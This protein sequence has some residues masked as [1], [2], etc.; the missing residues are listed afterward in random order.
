MYTYPNTKP[1]PVE[2]FH[3]LIANTIRELQDKVKAPDALAA[4]SCLTAM[5]V[6]CQGLIDVKSP[7]GQV[8]PVSLDLLCLAESGERKSTLDNLASVALHAADDMRAGRYQI[9]LEEYF[10][11]KRVWSAITEALERE[12]KKAAVAGEPIDDIK[13][14]LVEHLRK[15]PVK[16]RLRRMMR[17]RMADRA[18]MEALQG[19][20]ESIGLTTDEG[21]ITLNGKAMGSL[22]LKNSTW[23]GA[24]QLSWDGAEGSHIVVKN[25]RV[26]LSVMVQPAV[27]AEYLSRHGDKARGSGFWARHLVA[28]PASTQGFRFIRYIEDTWHH[29]PKFHERVTELLREYDDM[30]SKGLVQRKIIEFSE[31][32]IARWIDMVNQTE[33]ML[34]PYGYLNDIKDFASKAMEIAVRVAALLHHFTKQE[35]KITVDTLNR[36]ID[37]VEW[38]LHEFK[39]LFSPQ[40]QAPSDQIDAAALERYLLTHY[41]SKGVSAAPRNSVLRNGPVRPVAAFRAALDHLER[42]NKIWIGVGVGA[43]HRTRYINPGPNF[44]PV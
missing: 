34:Q 13:H 20:G 41:Y 25:P 2:A 19:D 4:M 23:D 1:Y 11:E 27:L 31:E 5:S 15:E 42:M 35:G 43:S 8:R 6:S 37:I 21:G 16:P 18:F 28:M 3:F 22:G 30:I 38:H 44:G 7:S 33:A 32:A 9:S 39:R 36:A 29:L 40:Y 17:Q 12:L 24:R 14:R 10:V 26:T